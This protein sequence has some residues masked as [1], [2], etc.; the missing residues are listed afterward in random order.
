MVTL[1]DEPAPALA[2][3]RGHPHP[4]TGRRDPGATSTPRAPPRRARCRWWRTST[5]AAGCR[6]ISRPITVSARGWPST[7]ARSSSPSTTGWRPSTSSRPR[8]RIAWP[9]T[10]GFALARRDIGG[11]PAPRRRWP[12]TPPAATSRPSSRSSRRPPGRPVPTCQALIYPG[13][14]FSFET[15]SHRELVDGHVIPRDRILWYM[16]Q[17]LGSEADRS[18]L[19][20]SPLRAAAWP[21]SRRP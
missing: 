9:P 14:D 8:S 18:D 5:A 11:D 7:P 1:M 10:A 4:G 16:E 21:A 15:T 2:A 20:A 19:R 6:A 12:A 17:Y 3:H 13:L